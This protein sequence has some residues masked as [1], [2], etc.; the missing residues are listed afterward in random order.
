MHR[1]FFIGMP[2]CGKTFW[3][4]QLED[5][6]GWKRFDTDELIVTKTGKSIA[7]IFESKGELFFRKIESSVLQ[8]L[9][10]VNES[11]V[12]STGGGLPLNSN[13]FSLMKQ[14]GTTIYLQ[15]SISLLLNNLKKEKEQRPLLK[16]DN[17]EEK[18]QQLFS[19]RKADYE[20]ADYIFNVEQL[21]LSQILTIIQQ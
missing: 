20:Q 11:F 16:G 8:E 17:V 15:A 9:I 12:C 2:G 6:L 13:N 21:T 19:K 3:A 5:T 10:E 1:L 7:S 14:N 4:K 18:L